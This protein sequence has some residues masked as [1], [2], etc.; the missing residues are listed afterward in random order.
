VSIDLDLL[1]RLAEESAPPGREERVRAI[2]TPLL[3]ATCDRVDEDPLGGVTGVRAA[4][5]DGGA[6]PRRLMLAAHMD[7]I[8]LMVT[9]VDERGFARVIPL[10]GWD[11]RTLVGQRVRVHGRRD[12]EGVVGTTPVHLLTPE[13]KEKAPKLDALAID[14]GLPAERVQE[15]VRPGD[16]AT[17]VRALRRLGD[18]VTGK[19]LDD[20]VGLFVM[21]EALRRA[22]RGEVEVHATATVQEEVGLRG[23]RVAAARIR[24]DV[25]LAIDTCPANDG[26][27]T[28]ANGPSTRLGHGTA[29]RVMDASAIGAPALV[30]LLV[31]IA[32]EEGIPHQLHLADRGGTDTGALQL[33]GDGAVAGCVS[34]PTRY[35]H[36]SV[37]ACHPDDVE[38]S[39]A[40]VAALIGR[41]GELEDGRRP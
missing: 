26:P 13:E 4:A 1:R 17:R 18:L 32:E 21:L 12:L 22:P 38:A 16:T 29:I 6:R 19:S 27:G 8:A 31:R 14:I 10:G 9:H 36:S 35:V 5:G 40:L 33:A 20:R 23:A 34:I 25:A 37:E 11:A 3:R 7:E 15:L 30:E 24:P 41:V 2:V 28:P 39:V